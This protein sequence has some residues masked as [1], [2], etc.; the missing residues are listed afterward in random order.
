MFDSAPSTPPE[1][2]SSVNDIPSTTK[3][4]LRST[5]TDRNGDKENR[6]LQTAANQKAAERRNTGGAKDARPGDN[7]MRKGSN[8]VLTSLHSG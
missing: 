2:N 4:P 7:I 5:I 1:L 8:I 6:P 3:S